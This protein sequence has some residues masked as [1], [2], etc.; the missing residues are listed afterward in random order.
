MLSTR[1]IPCLDVHNG[2]T[3][4]GV[5]FNNLIDAGDPVE[6]SKMYNRSG[7]DE[8]C[9]LDIS[10]T[11]EERKIIY[12]V[13]SRVSEQCFIPLTVGGGVKRN[14]DIK[15]LLKSGADKVTINSAALND[16]LLIKKSSDNFGSQCIVLAIDAFKDLNNK[17]SGYNVATHGGKKKTDIDA[18]EWAK[19]GVKYGAGEILLTSMNS[20]GTK[21]G[22]DIELT[23]MI[24]TNVSV[25]VVASGGAGKPEDMVKVVLDG[26]ASAVLAASIFHYEIYSIENVKKEMQ[27][28]G[29]IVRKTW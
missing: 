1:V 21:S 3:V 12:D 20:D 6:L 2:R 16:P 15:N 5:N 19:L 9:F 13:V 8:I 23:S 10:A 28:Y 7:A 17:K 22:Y 27:D 26:Y 11:N 4:K 24:S 18:L 29:I 25:P 14:N